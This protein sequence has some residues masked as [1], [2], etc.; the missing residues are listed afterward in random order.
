M[1]EGKRDRF[2]KVPPE[3]AMDSSLSKRALRVLIALG[4]YTNQDWKCFPSQK[5]LA[6][7]TGMARQ[8]VNKAIQEL[9]VR[10]WLTKLK[11]VKTTSGKFSGN[12]YRVNVHRVTKN[13]KPC[14][15]SGDTVPVTTVATKPCHQ[16]GDTNN[17][18]K[19]P[20]QY[21]PKEIGLHAERMAM[22]PSS[23]G[24]SPILRIVSILEKGG[25]SQDKAF[26]YLGTL[27]PDEY[28][29]IVDGM[30][31]GTVSIRGAAH[32]L[33]RLANG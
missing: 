33:G 32:M 29:K 27:N 7:D 12:S 3:A 1:S 4:G 24:K 22:K 30:H 23:P 5:K 8:T 2:A 9:C 13:D 10:G 18:L 21:Q 14:H 16:G 28:A 11:S 31:E 20:K 15:H 26:E 6:Q 19:Q 17:P 25:M